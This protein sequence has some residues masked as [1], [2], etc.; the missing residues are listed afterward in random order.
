MTDEELTVE[1]TG[2]R[3]AEDAVRSIA[4]MTVD[5]VRDSRRG[6]RGDRHQEGRFLKN[7]DHGREETL[8]M[9]GERR[10]RRSTS[11]RGI[12]SR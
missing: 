11:R 1:T 5:L 2:E 6:D 4:V 9:A 8:V 7:G 3:T 10:G 12:V